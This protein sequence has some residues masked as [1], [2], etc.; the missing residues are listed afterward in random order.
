MKNEVPFYNEKEDNNVYLSEY[1]LT[2]YAADYDP[3]RYEYYLFDMDGDNTP[4]L[5]IRN[6][7]HE[8]YVFKYDAVSD[9]IV[10]WMEFPSHNE[11]FHG[12]RKIQWDCDGMRYG[13]YHYK[14]TE[15]QFDEITE[16]YFKA[17][18]HSKTAIKRCKYTYS[19]LFG[20][21]P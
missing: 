2:G 4:E 14:V 9:E 21:K 20:S 11:M 13:M 17:H 3:R 1:K 16:D 8:T 6:T 15:E 18:E 7:S 5:C 10:L 12:T 19:D